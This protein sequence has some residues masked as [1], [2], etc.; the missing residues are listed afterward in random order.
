L[1]KFRKLIFNNYVY[2][3]VVIQYANGIIAYIGSGASNWDI[4][5]DKKIANSPSTN[6]WYHIAVVR[7]N[8]NFYYFLNGTV[9]S[10]FTDSKSIYYS[11]NAL[12]IGTWLTSYSTHYINGYIQ[13]FR[14]VKGKALWTNNFTP[15][16][17]PY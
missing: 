8:T 2:A 6:T 5:V 16:N 14:I 9:T 1:R 13:N 7:D 3:G 4:A 11:N 17:K 10:Q 12:S 15:P